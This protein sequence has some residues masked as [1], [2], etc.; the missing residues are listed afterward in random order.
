MQ[1]AETFQVECPI[2]LLLHQVLQQ[3]LDADG[4]LGIVP[5]E[6]GLVSKGSLVLE[7]QLQLLAKEVV[8]MGGGDVVRSLDLDS[9]GGQPCEDFV[10]SEIPGEGEGADPGFFRW[11]AEL[12]QLQG[13][14]EEVTIREDPFR[15]LINLTHGGLG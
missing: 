2:C 1:F 5:A 12:V 10:E 15:E 9:L 13:F 11:D 8:Q 6:D 3:P 14:I 4:R 7:D